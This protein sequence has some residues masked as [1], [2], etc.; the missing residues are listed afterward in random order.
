[1]QW[2]VARN[3]CYDPVQHP[4]I[5]QSLTLTWMQ[6]RCVIPA[7]MGQTLRWTSP[8]ATAV[9]F[10]GIDGEGC[11]TWNVAFGS[12]LGQCFL[13]NPATGRLWNGVI[14]K[15]QLLAGNSADP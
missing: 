1:M 3:G 4:L 7:L 9:T 14:A 12:P 15:Y 13:F 11:E 10:I 8:L 5:A 2:M 6:V